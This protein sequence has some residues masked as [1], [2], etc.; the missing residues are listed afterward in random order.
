MGKRFGTGL[1]GATQASRRIDL[2]AKKE[3]KLGKVLKG[4]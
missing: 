2:K 1:S 3:K 4:I